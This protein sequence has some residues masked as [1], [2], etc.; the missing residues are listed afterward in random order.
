MEC[1]IHTVLRSTE[2][3]YKFFSGSCA[4][5]ATEVF[6]CLAYG[7]ALGANLDAFGRYHAETVI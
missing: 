6:I 1:N 5:V 3:S 7:F 4:T 2:N